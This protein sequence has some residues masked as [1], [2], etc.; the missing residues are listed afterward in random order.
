[1]IH[2]R[3]TASGTGVATAAI[4]K[5]LGTGIFSTDADQGATMVATAVSMVAAGRTAIS[6][7]IAEY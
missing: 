7:M 3:A 1:M 6:T 2:G 5:T 4:A